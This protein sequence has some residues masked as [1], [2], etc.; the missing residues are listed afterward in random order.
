MAHLDSLGDATNN[1][2]FGGALHTTVFQSL[3][4]ASSAFSLLADLTTV[5]S[6]VPSVLDRCGNLLDATLP[7]TVAQANNTDPA[8]ASSPQP[9]QVVQYYRA[10][11]LALGI[12]GYN[13]TAVFLN[14][15]DDGDAPDTP[16][17]ES[18]DWDLLRCLN[19]TIGSRILLVDS[20][21]GG[22]PPGTGEARNW[23]GRNGDLSGVTSIVVLMLMF[24]LS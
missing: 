12:D 1:S 5:K 18:T 19:S 4:T 3:N 9:E 8:T 20:D 16:L 11:S 15:E 23:A 17:P 7:Q 14:T 21:S 24:A 2:R 13:N 10:S 6:I 22:P